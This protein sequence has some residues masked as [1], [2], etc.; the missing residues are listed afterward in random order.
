MIGIEFQDGEDAEVQQSRRWRTVDII[1]SDEN[2]RC[3][4][5]EIEQFKIK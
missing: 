3:C 5:R 1:L 4:S 2:N